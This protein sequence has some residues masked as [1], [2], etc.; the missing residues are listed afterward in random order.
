MEFPDFTWLF[1]TVI[2]LL[3]ISVPLGFWKIIDIIIWI[4]K[5]I[6]ITIG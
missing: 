3:I 1:W 6:N 2:V 5:N 4:I